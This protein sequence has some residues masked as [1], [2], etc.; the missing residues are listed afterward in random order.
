MSF[1]WFVGLHVP[2]L[3]GLCTGNTALARSMWPRSY[4]AEADASA[5]AA[6]SAGGAASSS[7]MA[8]PA[9][10]PEAYGWWYPLAFFSLLIC[11]ALFYFG[12]A[13]SYPGYVGLEYRRKVEREEAEEAAQMAN[14]GS[15][16]RGHTGRDGYSRVQVDEEKEAGSSGNNNCCSH[17]HGGASSSRGHNHGRSSAESDRISS[18]DV[19]IDIAQM[20]RIVVDESGGDGGGGDDLRL[21]SSPSVSGSARASAASA[22]AIPASMIGEAAE[23]AE[24]SVGC[25]PPIAA[26]LMR[27][28]GISRA[29]V[30]SND[31]TA[32]DYDNDASGNDNDNGN[33]DSEPAPRTH[34]A[35]GDIEMAELPAAAAAG[36]GSA[37]A[38]SS[39][40]PSSAASSP[41]AM[42]FSRACGYCS[43]CRLVKPARAKHCYKC[44]ACVQK[45][46][47]H[48]PYVPRCPFSHNEHARGALNAGGFV[49]VSSRSLFLFRWLFFAC[50]SPRVDGS[51][52]VS[53]VR[54]T[55]TS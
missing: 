34:A 36:S 37:S 4:F 8:P 10:Y 1:S 21:A 14:G 40:P 12:T 52:T 3:L 49:R 50:F 51:R 6:S 39:S 28:L 31:Q 24:L 42:A 5:T 55:V 20:R 48:C 13:L 15:G 9:S 41:S 29:Q 18:T 43:I 38:L 23:A 16:A 19:R 44:K 27:S 33:G 32:D 7:A 47:H 46:D 11:T 26:P 53:V 2:I 35:N 30:H 17:A 54:T 45:F 22:S 25:A